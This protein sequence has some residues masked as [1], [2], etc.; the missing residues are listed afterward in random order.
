M[1]TE[2]YINRRQVPKSGYR[3]GGKDIRTAMVVVTHGGPKRPAEP[4]AADDAGAAA[5]T[6]QPGVR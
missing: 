6:A 4:E 3:K 5:Q 1:D 2:A